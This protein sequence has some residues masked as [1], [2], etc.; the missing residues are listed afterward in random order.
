MG[1]N[2][3]NRAG[4]VENYTNAFLVVAGVTL[5]MSLFLLWAVFGYLVSLGTAL[6]LRAGIELI[7]KQD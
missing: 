2:P 3:N 1:H 6:F 7:P 4:R 5:F